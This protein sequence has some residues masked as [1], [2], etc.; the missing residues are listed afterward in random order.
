[1]KNEYKS[2]EE[3]LKNYNPNKYKQL[4]LSTDIL[5]ISVNDEDTDNY[6]KNSKKK[7]S[8]LLIKR[9]NYPYKDKWCL[10][11][12]FLNP[13][14]E[15]LDDCTKRILKT[16]TNLSNIYLEQLYT[17]DNLNRDPRCRVIS[18]SYMALVDKN[19]LKDKINENASWFD[20]TLFDDDDKNITVVLDNNVDTIKFSI[21]KNLREL[22]TDR[23]TFEIKENKDL[24]FD[25]PLVI[26]AGIERLKN[27]LN[28][29]D[30]VFNMMPEYFTLGELQQVYEVILGKKLLDPAFR[31]IIANKVEKTSKMKTGSGHRPSYLFKY[32]NK[33]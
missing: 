24:A 13:E 25:H 16:E 27:K 28:Y 18:T 1:M 17:F 29:T 9:K 21:K 12:G 26:V 14:T 32:K 2:E 3:F 22:T 20:I 11:G 19:R 30:I 10:P 23:Y 8:I 4:S 31:R 15:T 5:L 33:K 7:M 6:R